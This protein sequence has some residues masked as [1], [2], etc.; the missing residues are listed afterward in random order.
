MKQV[1]RWAGPRMIYQHP[2]YAIIHLID[3]RKSGKSNPKT[4]NYL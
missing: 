2:F 4:L 3:S 1:M